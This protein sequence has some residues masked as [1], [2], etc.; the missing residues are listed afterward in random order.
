MRWEAVG[1]TEV[2]SRVRVQIPRQSARPKK[3]KQ[4]ARAYRPGRDADLAVRYMRVQL[5]PAHY[6]ADK[7]PI[8]IWVIHARARKIR[9]RIPKRW[10]GFC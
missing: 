4:Q 6:D 7:A 9:R 2:Q 8:A 5:R 10:S 1:Q 3:S